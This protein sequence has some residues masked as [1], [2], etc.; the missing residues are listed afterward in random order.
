[1]VRRASLL[2][3]LSP[4]LAYA[5]AVDSTVVTDVTL[6]EWIGV[7]PFLPFGSESNASSYLQ[8]AIPISTITVSALASSLSTRAYAAVRR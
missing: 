8:W 2:A 6:I 1:M 5:G 7:V 4:D 3:P